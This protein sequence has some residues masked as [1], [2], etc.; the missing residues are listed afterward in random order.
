[1]KCPKCGGDMVEKELHQIKIDQCGSCHGIYF[2]AGELDILL[3][4]KA[5]QG[6]LGGLKKLFK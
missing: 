1:M 3:Q 5:P 2:D 4:S 6:F